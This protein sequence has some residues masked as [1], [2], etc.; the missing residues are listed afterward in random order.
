M[1]MIDNKYLIHTLKLKHLLNLVMRKILQTTQQMNIVQ[2]QYLDRPEFASLVR[3]TC[4]YKEHLTFK[5]INT[6][7]W[8]G[9]NSSILNKLYIS[10]IP[11]HKNFP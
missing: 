3:K 5:V 4:I 6:F 9:V 8:D 7:Y 10:K 11:K 2:L 1:S